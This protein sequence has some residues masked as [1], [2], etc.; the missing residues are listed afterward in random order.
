MLTF[1]GTIS[2]P[3]GRAEPD[4]IRSLLANAEKRLLVWGSWI[5]CSTARSVATRIDEVDGGDHGFVW[6]L[7]SYWRYDQVQDGVVVGVEALKR[8]V[9]HD[10]E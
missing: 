10:V 5:A 6:R 8:Y 4:P 7:R 2:T 9:E 1:G 3:A